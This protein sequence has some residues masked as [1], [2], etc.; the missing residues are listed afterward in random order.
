MLRERRALWALI[1][2]TNLQS[3]RVDS[4]RQRRAVIG[5]KLRRPYISLRRFL[6]IKLSNV[7]TVPKCERPPMRGTCP[8]SST[9]QQSIEMGERKSNWTFGLVTT[10][11][12]LAIAH[13]HTKKVHSSLLLIRVF[14]YWFN[15][16][17]LRA[18]SV[19]LSI[20]GSKLFFKHKENFFSLKKQERITIYLIWVKISA[21]LSWINKRSKF[22]QE[23]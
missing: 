9:L 18:I 10:T 22:I 5:N 12:P 20:V 3:C 21:R 7:L 16:A 6:R 2:A 8:G 23:W 4:F 13:E 19:Q 1:H 17:S 11:K 15:M 14:A